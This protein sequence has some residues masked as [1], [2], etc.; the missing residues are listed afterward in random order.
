MLFS[1]LN[2]KDTSAS[3]SVLTSRLNWSEVIP[4]LAALSDVNVIFPELSILTLLFASAAVVVLIASAL[5]NIKAVNIPIRNLLVIL[6]S[7]CSVFIS[8]R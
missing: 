5:P 8:Q 2:A 4:S 1:E 6:C 7:F 3:S